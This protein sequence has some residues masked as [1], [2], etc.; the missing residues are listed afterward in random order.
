MVS[1]I[2]YM[3]FKDFNFKQKVPHVMLFAVALGIS[4]ISFDPPKVLFMFFMIYGF[5]GPMLFLFRRLRRKNIYDS[6]LS[7]KNQG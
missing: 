1:N 4:F 7:S 5:S 6:K 3:S 2:A